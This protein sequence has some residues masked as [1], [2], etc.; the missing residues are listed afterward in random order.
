MAEILFW[1][2]VSRDLFSGL[3][4]W[5]TN[6]PGG[7]GHTRLGHFCRC[8]GVICGDLCD[9]VQSTLPELKARGYDE[10]LT[11]GA[12]AGSDTLGLLFPPSV[13]GFVIAARCFRLVF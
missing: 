1:S 4:P 9:C 7:L 3:A 12:I 2:R 5:L 11:L 8:F 10:K 6:L 13:S